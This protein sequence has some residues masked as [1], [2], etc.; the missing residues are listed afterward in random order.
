VSIKCGLI[1]SFADPARSVFFVTGVL[2]LAGPFAPRR[3]TYHSFAADRPTLPVLAFA[4]RHAPRATP[5]S[6]VAAQHPGVHIGLT[7]SGSAR[8]FAPYFL[9]SNMERRHVAR[10]TRGVE[11]LRL[12]KH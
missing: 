5:L 11:I 8:T 12:H 3:F 2:R 4:G 1:D 9:S 10:A 7:L 6:I